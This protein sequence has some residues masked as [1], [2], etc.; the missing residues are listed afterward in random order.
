MRLFRFERNVLFLGLGAF[1][2][3]MAVALVLAF[4]ELHGVARWLL[5]GACV[6]SCALYVIAVR[7]QLVYPL[8]TLASFIG[9]IR[10]EDYSFRVRRASG[11][12]MAEVI[13]DLDRLSEALRT[14]RLEAFESAALV[15][16]IL[17]GIDSAIFAFD[18]RERLQLV[19]HA[20]ERLLARN[21]EQ[22]LGR[23]AEELGLAPLLAGAQSE[24]AELALPGASGR[25]LVRRSRFRD[26]GVPHRLLVLSDLS[27]TLREEERI[28]WQRLLRVLGHELNNSLAPI[29]SIALSLAELFANDDA[30][31][32]PDDWL[33]DVRSGLA[34][35]GARTAGLARFMD[36]YA[37]LA[38]LPR[39]VLRRTPIAELVARLPELEQRLPLRVTCDE[40]V[41]VDVDRDQLEQLLIN[42]A[43]NA[44]DASLEAGEGYV[45]I[46]CATRGDEVEVAI[47]DDGAGIAS[48]ANLFVPFF[49]TKAGGS[50]VGLALSRQI[51]EAH[52]GTLT[53][54]NRDGARGAVARLRL[55]RAR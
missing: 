4:K 11:G 31:A 20:G 49:T 22:L 12:A 54:E 42:L 28:A 44:V 19:N 5:L 46:A 9:A 34:V 41:L 25:W 33:D 7:A 21:T 38:R 26:N 6:I 39:P 8:R 30:G 29:R 55:P 3:L 53:L 32:R 43:R 37:R 52:G 47:E 27:R 45:A 14:R 13:A 16:A 36:G 10:E 15:R 23:S 24:T 17:A 48:T 2:P 35:I 1:V 50:G 18:A 40:D 51:A